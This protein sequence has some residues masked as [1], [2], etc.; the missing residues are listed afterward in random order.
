MAATTRQDMIP[1]GTPGH[2][3]QHE[4]KDASI[5]AILIFAA[6][7]TVVAV[8][9]HL[10]LLAWLEHFSNE[11]RKLQA[12]R[13]ELFSDEAGQFPAPRLQDNPALDMSQMTEKEQA[14]LDRY[15]WV[16]PGKVARIPIGRAMEMVAA[17]G[18]RE[19]GAGA[20]GSGD[21]TN[22]SD[23]PTPTSPPSD[24]EGQP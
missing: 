19:D 2:G 9:F 20:E 14:S 11:N 8:I 10:G 5:R 24:P 21:Q 12:N 3:H 13:P 4:H 6:S 16:E 18:P 7:L 22:P 15:G 17:S 23:P 1:Q